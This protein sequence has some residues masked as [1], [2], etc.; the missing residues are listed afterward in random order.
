MIK[1]FLSCFTAVMVMAASVSIMSSAEGKTVFSDNF[2]SGNFSKWSN[3]PLD[4]DPARKD[5]ECE[6]VAK[7]KDGAMAINNYATGGS[8]F[9]I[10]AKD[11]KMLN[12]TM[13]MKVKSNRF[14]D[15]WMG[16]S[17]RKDLNDRF[18][19]CNNN[20][21]ALRFQGDKSVA[22]Q[23][24]R[25][26]PGSAPALLT[27]AIEVPYKQDTSGWL[28]WR[29]E[30][31]GSSFKSFVNGQQ[32]GEWTY[33]KNAN[34]GYISVNACVFDGAVDDVVIQEYQAGGE[35]PAT[36]TKKGATTTKNNNTTA[37]PVNTTTS[38]KNVEV[39]SD[40]GTGADVTETTAPSE[41]SG[42]IKSIYKDVTV[43]NT[44]SSI[45]LTREL[46][47]KDLLVSFKLSD[48]YSLKILD[49]NDAEVADTN[50]TVTDSMKVKVV[51]GSED[52]KTY[53]INLDYKSGTD[54][55]DSSANA[56]WK[57]SSNTVLIIVIMAVVIAGGVV[58]LLVLKKKHILFK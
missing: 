18:N 41:D 57:G 1:K 13:T 17:F 10:G 42:F 5:T 53:T 34:E 36:T 40:S 55:D 49:K 31:N 2:S 54:G 6:N 51:R 56:D 26:Y 11:I 44:F 20:I 35:L 22:A 19:G 37:A 50:T 24:Y 14:D 43:D 12:F 58:T 39:T 9:Y 52:I 23:M 46:K 47:V 21:M 16:V 45:K 4:N 7:I 25:G 30:V 29:L 28:S 48:G 33:T 27:N 15:S 3:P 8:F 38:S 32:I